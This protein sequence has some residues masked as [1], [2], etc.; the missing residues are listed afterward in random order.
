M[1]Q[2]HHG[3][4][5]RPRVVV[6]GGGIAGLSAAHRLSGADVDVTL[7]EAS[8]QLGGLGTFFRSGQDELERFYHCIM[9]TDDSLLALLESIGL[10]DDVDW[11]RT[12][13]GIVVRGRRYPFNTAIDLLRFTPL[14][15]LERVRLGAMSLALRRLGKGKDLDHI[16]TEDWLRG[17]YGDRI[18]ETLW[19]PLFRSKFGSHVGDVPALYLWQRLGREKNVSVRGYPSG[20][21]KRII[22]ALRTAIETRGGVVRTQSVVERL[23]DKGPEMTVQLTS[24][25]VL[26]ADWVVSTIPL[27]LL[28]DVAAGDPALSASLP[29]VDLP[30]QG[31]VNALFFLRRPL[32]NRYWTPVL[33]SGTDFDGVVEMSSLTGRER[34]SGRHLAYAMKYTDRSSLLFGEDPADIADRW[35][36]QLLDLFADLP[37]T[38]EDVLGVEVFKA[39]FVEPSYPLG[40]AD[41]KPGIAVGTSRLLL[42]TTAQIYPR[43]TAWNSSVW[44]SDQVVEHLL[45]RTA[46]DSRS[47]QPDA[48]T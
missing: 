36:R 9:P 45:A 42:D 7:L 8:D 19:E 39:P 48:R 4:G 46:A 47:Y 32:D 21:Y 43:V 14:S 6:L 16:R 30:Y 35:T 29:S 10:R 23:E 3:S 41:S 25:E 37:L 31:V 18:W 24:G 2:P 15:L 12:T 33:A 40:Y 38:R 11:R 44:L 13:M 20:G 26:A 5:S 34:Y 17:L 28:R 1:S 27:P 22:D